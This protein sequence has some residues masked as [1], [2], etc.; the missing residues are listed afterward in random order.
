MLCY[1][2]RSYVFSSASAVFVLSNKCK[3]EDTAVLRR[4]DTDVICIDDIITT[5][6]SLALTEING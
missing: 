6:N 3:S 2:T 5:N 1:V 4:S